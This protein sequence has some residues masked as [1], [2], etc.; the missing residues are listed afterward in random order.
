MLSLLGLLRWAVRPLDK[1]VLASA[2]LVGTALT[3]PRV[4]VNVARFGAPKGLSQYAVWQ[5]CRATPLGIYA[6]AG[7]VH[8][9]APYTGSI[10][11]ML[12]EM[13]DTKARGHLVKKSLR[14][15]ERIIFMGFVRHS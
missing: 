9:A 11:P 15:G 1:L 7:F 4:V 8:F 6:F 10:T 12:T 2:A 14:E 13:T 5:A 3:L